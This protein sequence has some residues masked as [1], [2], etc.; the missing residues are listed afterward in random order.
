MTSL[1]FDHI[2]SPIGEILLVCDGEGR[3][4]ALDFEEHQA[5]LQL[6]L[7]RYHAVTALPAAGP[8]PAGIHTALT[9]FFAGDLDAIN[10]VPVCFRGTAFQRR[11]WGALRGIPAGATMTYGQLGTAVGNPRACRAVGLAN[12]ANPIA[13]IVP[14]H[15]VTGA[16][17]TLTGYGGG[18]ERKRWLLAHE[19]T[20]GGERRKSA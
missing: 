2:H 15:R 8:A 20:W 5:R 10:S 3:V 16:D 14:C 9:A 1:V 11:V 12:G 4:V 13:I 7:R 19:R 17:G 6:L 18:L